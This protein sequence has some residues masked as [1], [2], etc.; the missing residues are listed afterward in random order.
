[1]L[2][3]CSFAIIL[4]IIV[5]REDDLMAIDGDNSIASAHSLIVAYGV[6]IAE[7]IR[8]SLAL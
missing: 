1:M 6:A 2:F 7:S 3:I 4:N 5:M 8:L